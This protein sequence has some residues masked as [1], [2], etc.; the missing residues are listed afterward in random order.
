MERFFWRGGAE[1][2][3]GDSRIVRETGNCFFGARTR[4][5]FEFFK[6]AYTNILQK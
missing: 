2:E 6:I 3:G 1:I 4:A 5:P